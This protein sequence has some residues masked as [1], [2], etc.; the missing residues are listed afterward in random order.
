MLN[1]TVK[2]MIITILKKLTKNPCYGS[3]IYGKNQP[4]FRLNIWEVY[5]QNKSFRSISLAIRCKL[6]KFMKN[7]HRKQ[8]D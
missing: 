7:V 8:E 6:N 3:I 1:V 4:L 5:E 2:N